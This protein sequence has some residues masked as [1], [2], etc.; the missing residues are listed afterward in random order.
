[1]VRDRGI[2]A[3][4]LGTKCTTEAW[5]TRG[6]RVLGLVSGLPPLFPRGRHFIV[7]TAVPPYYRLRETQFAPRC[8]RTV[9]VVT[10]TAVFGT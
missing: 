10:S 8:P 3:C 6:E 2:C 4:L 9:A 5:E 1:M 7:N